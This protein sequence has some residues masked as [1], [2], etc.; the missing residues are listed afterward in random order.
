MRR[1]FRLWYLTVA[2]ILQVGPWSAQ[3]ASQPVKSVGPGPDLQEHFC[4]TYRVEEMVFEGLARKQF[5]D[6]IWIS[7]NE[8]SLALAAVVNDFPA[9]EIDGRKFIRVI[10]ASELAFL[11]KELREDSFVLPSL[12]DI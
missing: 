4:S 7:L 9:K 8:S 3:A 2:A 6:G 11:A 10:S 1:H 12:F 5:E